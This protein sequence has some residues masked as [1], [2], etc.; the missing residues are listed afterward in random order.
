MTLI[1]YN[2]KVI[3]LKAGETIWSAVPFLH[4]GVDLF[5]QSVCVTEF[6]ISKTTRHTDC[7]CAWQ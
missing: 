7:Y 4:D 5:L 3:Y 2:E 1:T 6:C